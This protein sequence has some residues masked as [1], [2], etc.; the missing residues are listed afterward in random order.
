[1][2]IYSDRGVMVAQADSFPLSVA[3]PRMKRAGMSRLELL[4]WSGQPVNVGMPP[5]QLQQYQGA[6]LTVS[7][8]SVHR[9][10]EDHRAN[11][12]AIHDT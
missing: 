8:W 3:G 2:S 9:P 5:A 7:A 12:T 1:M 4:L 11:L 10:G 6:G